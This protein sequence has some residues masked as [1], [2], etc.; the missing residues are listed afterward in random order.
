MRVPVFYSAH[1]LAT[2]LI[3]PI[4]KRRKGCYE[5]SAYSTL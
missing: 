3:Q 2:S 4:Q 5:R 1:L